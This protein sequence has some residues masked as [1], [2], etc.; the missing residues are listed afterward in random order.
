[1]SFRAWKKSILLRYDG[2]IPLGDVQANVIR[3]YI[4]GWQEFDHIDHILRCMGAMACCL[5]REGD[6]SA[7]AFREALCRYSPDLEGR[8]LVG[9][10]KRY[11]DPGGHFFTLAHEY[12]V[13]AP[14]PD[15]GD[16]PGAVRNR[17][18]LSQRDYRPD[19]LRALAEKSPFSELREL[20]EKSISEERLAAAMRE[21]D[22]AAVDLYMLWVEPYL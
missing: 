17:I 12:P 13:D 8:E 5:E 14:D 20:L 2:S 10:A 21:I 19:T 11:P 18:F 16:A 3:R 15:Q 6:E 1:M 4:D 22:N 7:R 9:V